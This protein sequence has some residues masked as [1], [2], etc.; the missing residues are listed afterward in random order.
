MKTKLLVASILFACSGLAAAQQVPP[1]SVPTAKP[2]PA[3]ASA[4]NYKPTAAEV[5]QV[6]R[7]TGEY[8]S[9]LDRHWYDQAYAMESP[10]LQ[11]QM[12]LADWKV[13]QRETLS[14]NGNTLSRQRTA[15]SWFKDPP[16]SDGPGLYVIV[17]FTGTGE[18]TVQSGEYVMWYRPRG[19]T[20]F[21]LLRHEVTAVH[22]DDPVAYATAHPVSVTPMPAVTPAKDP[23]IGFARVAEARAALIQR[24]GAKVTSTADGWLV[25]VEAKPPVVWSFTPPG[26][27]A[28][29]AVVRRAAVQKEGKPAIETNAICEAPQPACQ[30]LM[31]EFAEMNRLATQAAAPKPA[32]PAVKPAAPKPATK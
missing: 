26:A 1:A 18:N 3:I 15:V 6:D 27:P 17:D 2:A 20:A 29:P 31:I 16:D 7:L 8:F 5:D 22:R 23:K 30:R 19:E 32:A 14:I 21:R 4:P 24:P 12:S 28:Y 11:K 25:V 10:L 13:F 9:Y